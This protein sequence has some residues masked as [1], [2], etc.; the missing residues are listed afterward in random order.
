M[1]HVS[2][3]GV[4]NACELLQSTFEDHAFLRLEFE[5]MVFDQDAN[6]YLNQQLQ[7]GRRLESIV[8]RNCLQPRIE[9]WAKVEALT[10]QGSQPFIGRISLG[11]Q[12]L[13]LSLTSISFS[14]DLA[15][16][17]GRQ[18][19][20]HGSLQ[21]L[22]CS[23]SKFLYDGL[24]LFVE[25]LSMNRTL[26]RVIFVDCNL[27]DEPLA[28]LLNSL[29]HNQP[30]VEVD[31]SFNKC[32]S[33]GVAALA[34]LA[35]HCETLQELSM[36]FQAF[37]KS[38][39]IGLAPL[40]RALSE[41]SSKLMRL[42][43]GGNNL[44]DGDIVDLLDMLCMKSSV[45]AVELSGNRL[46]DHGTEMIAERLKDIQGLR[47]LALEENKLT[48]LS[49]TILAKSL[50]S[51]LSLEDLDL[52]DIIYQNDMTRETW[53]RLAYYLDLNWGG[54]RL[55]RGHDSIPL[56]LWPTLLARASRSRG[57]NFTRTVHEHDITYFIIQEIANR[58]A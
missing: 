51:N 50:E 52:D 47:Y 14:E 48:H 40:F 17:L 1:H 23:E 32:R 3:F 39:R 21:R 41:S 35:T 43:I 58:L 6:E 13:E 10:L 18:I 29:S 42:E 49:L 44:C 36:G 12:L 7:A 53:T 57:L 45:T 37:G 22:D 55:V 46:S 8:F 30:L 5:G 15:A 4:A 28:Q 20:T 34:N 27:M 38:K 19:G 31:I 26:A 11:D 9:Y 33:L 2:G 16:S 25:G 54:R 24:R 56:S